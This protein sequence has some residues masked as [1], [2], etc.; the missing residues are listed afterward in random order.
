MD[1]CAL[2]ARAKKIGLPTVGCWSVLFVGIMLLS[3]LEQYS[4]AAV[5]HCRCG[6][7]QSGG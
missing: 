7:E 3:E 5:S 6:F 4:R 1:L 2:D